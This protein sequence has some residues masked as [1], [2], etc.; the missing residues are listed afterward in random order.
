MIPSYISNDKHFNKTSTVKTDLKNTLERLKTP[1]R[2]QQKMGNSSTS[3]RYNKS[4]RNS[5]AS[6]YSFDKIYPNKNI[7]KT[8]TKKKK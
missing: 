5:S 1:L 4:F 3:L 8:K 2:E 6:E 7:L